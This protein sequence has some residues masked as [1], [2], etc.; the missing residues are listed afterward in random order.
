LP[1]FRHYLRGAPQPDL[2]EATI[3][4]TGVN[5][6]RTFDEWPPAAVVETAIHLTADG[7]LSFSA[8]TGEGDSFDEFVSDPAKP[9]PYTAEIT[10]GW[11]K[12]YMTEDQRF[13]ARRPDVL[14]YQTEVLTEDLTL[15]GPIQADLWV[16][17]SETDADWIVKVIDVQP[18]RTPD[19]DANPAGGRQTLVRAEAIR[20]RFR[21]S[22]ERPEPFVPNQPTRLTFPLQDVM[23]T[24][25]RG[26]R[27]MV[28][29][30]STWFPFI[31][32]NPQTWVE[33]IFAAQA[34]DFVPATH[35]VHHTADHP[36]RLVLGIL[37]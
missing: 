19:C 24:F 26:H 15:A 4:E 7:R 25:Q 32:R 1:F 21:N 33:N 37:E 18:E 5:R 29:V 31:D 35:R 9:V 34:D 20:G 13:A 12:K 23:H 28:Q 36:S 2:P 17:T 22:Y 10:N 3:F 8:P 30:Q 14:V 27:L 11:A 6:W 16:S